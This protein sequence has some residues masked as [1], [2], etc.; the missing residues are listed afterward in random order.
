MVFEKPLREVFTPLMEDEVLALLPV[1][2]ADT[3]SGCSGFFTDVQLPLLTATR[4]GAESPTRVT[5]LTE[6]RHFHLDCLKHLFTLV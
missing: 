3:N 1:E 5:L 2:A 6:R 4:R